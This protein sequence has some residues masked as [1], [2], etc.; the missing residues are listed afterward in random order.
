MADLDSVQKQNMSNSLNA[1]NETDLNIA[2]SF[3]GN[4][5][6]FEVGNA[7]RFDNILVTAVPEPTSAGLIGIL[8]LGLVVRRRR[9]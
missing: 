5:G 4:A 3:V 7:V 1:N 9:N 6:L 2:F 8:G